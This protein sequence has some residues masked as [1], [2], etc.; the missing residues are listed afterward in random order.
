MLR[1]IFNWWVDHVLES[2]IGQISGI[3][4]GIISETAI[5]SI[6]GYSSTFSTLGATTSY[7]EALRVILDLY[8]I[9][10]VITSPITL[11]ASL[12]KH[13]RTGQWF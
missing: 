6:A 2:A 7:F 4:L 8:G 13:S 12:E 1:D 3:I 9:I 11:F 10:S 5:K